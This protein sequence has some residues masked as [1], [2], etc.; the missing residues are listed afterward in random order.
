MRAKLLSFFG[1]FS[2]LVA[3]IHQE[4]FS[5]TYE[6][7]LWGMN[8]QNVG[9]SGGGSSFNN[10]ILYRNFIEKIIRENNIQS[11]V[12]IGCGD[13]EFSKFMDW[14]DAEYLGV[15]VVDQV[16]D[17]NIM[18]FSS[19]RI[20]FQS[21]NFLNI[22]IPAA[23]L[24]LCKHVCQHISNHDVM[25]IVSQIHKFK[26]CVFVNPVDPETK[27]CPN[28][29]TE[30]S[31]SGRLIDLTKPPFNLS[32]EVFYYMLPGGSLQQVLHIKKEND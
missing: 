31:P 7:A 21:V 23:D 27:T 30:V 9:W 6:K 14:G 29:D 18:T 15:D 10:T 5:E 17:K 24:L 19:E 16:I 20:H 28:V 2:C 22:D 26:H 32:G 3:D 13:W 8:Q 12:D 11:V 25:D 4:V 1:L